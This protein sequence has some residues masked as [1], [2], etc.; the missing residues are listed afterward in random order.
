MMLRRRAPAAH[1]GATAA[2]GA[3]RQSRTTKF[4]FSGE[5]TEFLFFCCW[6]NFIPAAAVLELAEFCYSIITSG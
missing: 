1:L 5:L 2:S 4:Q 6:L 3:Q